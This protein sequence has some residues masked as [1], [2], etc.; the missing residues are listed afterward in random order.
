MENLTK[1]YQW[2]KSDN[3]GILETL[4]DEDDEML[5]FESGRRLYKSVAN[6][7][8]ME[9]KDGEAIIPTFLQ[10]NQPNANIQQNNVPQQPINQVVQQVQTNPIQ[11]ALLKTKKKQTFY[12]PIE[13]PI[14][15]P[16]QATYEFLRG[17]IYEEFELDQA[18]LAILKEYMKNID[19]AKLLEEWFITKYKGDV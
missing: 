17:D 6:E 3:Y 9:Y 12:I 7:F 5:Y 11:E 15:L 18:Y 1:T 4:R 14:E 16:T 8:L 19:I 10:T 13:L 2:I